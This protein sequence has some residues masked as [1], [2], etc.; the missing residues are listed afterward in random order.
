V[1]WQLLAAQTGAKLRFI[2]FDGQGMLQ[3]DAYDRLLSDRTKL[4]AVTHV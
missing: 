1:P 4:V 3:L 2:A